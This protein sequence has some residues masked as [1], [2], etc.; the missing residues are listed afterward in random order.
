MKPLI[1]CIPIV[2]AAALAHAGQPLP[3]EF[4]NRGN[5]VYEGYG[6]MNE[7]Y[8]A[9]GSTERTLQEYY[10]RRQYPGSPP[11]IPHPAEEVFGE[12]IECLACHAD[13]GWVEEY[14]RHAPVTP[15]P[16]NTSCRQCHVLPVTVELFRE[17]DW[18][19]V[20]PPRLGGSAL[21]GSPPP[22]PHRLQMR[23]NCLACH[24]G[25]GA[26][27]SIRSEHA[28]RGN[29]RQCHVPQETDEPFERTGP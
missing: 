20:P 9:G 24:A 26:V 1:F 15:H 8:R 21:P 19:S 11:Y 23:E 6:R 10:S 16:E 5:T 22:V 28:E 27:T 17:T 13:G 29:C 2:L 14:K 3:A 18:M 12:E 7:A 25:P 4:D